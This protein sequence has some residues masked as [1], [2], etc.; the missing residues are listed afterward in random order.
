VFERRHQQQIRLT[1]PQRVD[2]AAASAR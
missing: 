2:A 1:G